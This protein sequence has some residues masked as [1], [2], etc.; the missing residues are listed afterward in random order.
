[1]QL[2]HVLEL[3]EALARVRLRLGEIR[4]YVCDLIFEEGCAS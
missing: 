1:M 4:L 3:L 2:L